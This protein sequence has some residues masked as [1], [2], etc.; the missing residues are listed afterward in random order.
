MAVSV[1][2]VN[3]KPN[4]PTV[5]EFLLSSDSDVVK[6]PKSSTNGTLETDDSTLNEPCDFG[7]M[8]MVVTGSST[9]VY[10]L[11]PEDKWVKM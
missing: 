4:S 7:S 11:S 6:L 5:K 8:A 3:G 2:T 9:T 10:I 1:T